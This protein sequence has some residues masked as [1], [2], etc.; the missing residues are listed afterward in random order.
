[1]AAAAGSYILYLLSR[2]ET[3]IGLGSCAVVSAVLLG[4]MLAF[5]LAAFW[6]VILAVGLIWLVRALY[7]YGSLVSAALDALLCVAS[8]GCALWAIFLGGNL[9]VGIWTFLLVQAL[10]VFIPRSLFARAGEAKP[11]CA[12]KPDRFQQA[13]HAALEALGRLGGP[14]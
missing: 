6:V 13:H 3:K 5:N 9:L 2:A 4:G 8:L 10:F 1:M 11:R 14:A 7:A 12:A